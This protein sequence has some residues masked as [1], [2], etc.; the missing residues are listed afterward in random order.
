MNLN[1]AVPWGFPLEIKR[2]NSTQWTVI[3]SV[4]RKTSA[5]EH[6]EFDSS[7]GWSFG[8]QQEDKLRLWT[9]EFRLNT[10]N[11]RTLWHKRIH[12]LIFEST[13]CA[14]FSDNFWHTNYF[15]CTVSTCY[16]KAVLLA[17][18]HWR[19]QEQIWNERLNYALLAERH[20]RWQEP[21]KPRFPAY[22]GEVAETIRSGDEK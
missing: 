16:R 6:L 20:W 18:R 10:M 15:A 19:W 14:V 9:A 22:M 21:A 12:W 2:L 5:L 4:C 8:S 11:I 13:C 1:S 7:T 17:E 3:E